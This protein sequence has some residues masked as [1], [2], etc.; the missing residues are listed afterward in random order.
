[1]KINKIYN[2]KTKKKNKKISKNINKEKMNN[3][4]ISKNINNKKMNKKKI[5][6]NINKEKMN[7]MIKIAEWAQEY[8]YEY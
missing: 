6:E 2:E 4:K 3:K 7:K 8:E 5:S 1:M